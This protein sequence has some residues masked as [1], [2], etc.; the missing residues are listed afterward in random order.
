MVHGFDQNANP[1]HFGAFTLAVNPGAPANDLCTG[2]TVIPQGV[3]PLS[4]DGTI[5]GA[6]TEI[7]T[8]DEVAPVCPTTVSR[9]VW[10]TFTAPG[11]NVQLGLSTCNAETEFDTII[12]VY[13]DDALSYRGQGSPSSETMTCVGSN[14][15]DTSDGTCGGTKSQLEVPTEA[16][17]TYRILVHGNLGAVDPVTVG[18][19]KLEVTQ[20]PTTSPPSGLGNDQCSQVESAPASSPFVFTGPGIIT[21][22]TTVGAT[23]DAIQIPDSC[24][25]QSLETA[26]IHPMSSLKP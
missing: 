17:K 10:Y 7:S 25:G 9:G 11:F 19:F 14:D 5:I 18:A 21:V 4:F 15:N 13:Q 12:S 1:G 2:A 23:S 3:S 24:F 20:S 26:T 22:Q 16:G 6:T 8:F